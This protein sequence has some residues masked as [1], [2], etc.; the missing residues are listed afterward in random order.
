MLDYLYPTDERELFTDRHYHLGL[1]EMCCTDLQQGRR[2]HL[3]LLGLRRIGKTLILKE[4]ILRW[5]QR[6]AAPGAPPVIPIYMDLKRL[7]LS[8]ESFAVEYIGSVLYWFQQRG[9]GRWDDYARLPTLLRAAT[10]LGNQRVLDMVLELDGALRQQAIPQRRLLE[11]AFEFPQVL[12]REVGVRFVVCMDEFQ[13]LRLLSNF[14]QVGDAL[15]IFRALLQTQSDV[16]YVAAGSAIS[17]MEG[18]FHQARSPLFVHFRSERVGPFTRAESEELA[19]KALA[20]E[21]LP[22]ESAHTL[23]EWTR[24]HPFYIYAVA[25]RMRELLLLSGRAADPQLVREAFVLE[26]LSSAGRIYNLCRYVIEESMGQARGQALLRLL[27]QILAEAEDPLTLT[28]IA[29]RL[30]RPAGATRALLN[31]LGEVDL[32]TQ[33]GGTYDLPDP[34][35]K[36]WLA[37]FHAGVELLTVPR[38]EIL[39]GLVADM[40]QRYQ[41][42]SSE[43]GLAKESQVRELLRAFD[44]QVVDGALFGRSG[45]LTLPTFA[46]VEPATAADSSW[47]IDALADTEGDIAERWAVEVKWRNR[48]ADYHDVVRFHA[49]ALNLNA[50]PWFIAKTGLTAAAAGYARD[51]G[52]LVSTERELQALAERLGVRFGK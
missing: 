9:Q 30:R 42:I 50:R 10:A 33:A 46:R 27:L 17:L 47:E 20:G 25:E 1:L 14:P 19:R 12:A 36:L 5:L 37:Y 13:D 40:T 48:R 8:P 43:L 22:A 49:T 7:G 29:S 11:L 23:Y 39:E 35:L 18:I 3:A 44:G 34:V 16:A 4:F 32:V 6:P 41:R 52:L 45:Q 21:E 28:E 38:R 26:T 15:D 24:G 2:K 51:K 31:R